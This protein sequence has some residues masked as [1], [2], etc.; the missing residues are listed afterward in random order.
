MGVFAAG[1]LNDQ[2]AT[3]GDEGAEEER[4]RQQQAG[5]QD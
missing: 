3:S 1:Q 4:H 2:T 5:A